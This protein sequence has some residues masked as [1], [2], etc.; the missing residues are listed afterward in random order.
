MSVIAS[1]SITAQADASMQ[2]SADTEMIDENAPRP[3]YGAGGPEFRALSA[4]EINGGDKYRKVRIPPHRYTPLRNNWENIMRPLVEHM[5]IQVRFNPKTRMVEMKT[6]ENTEYQGAL[7]KS[8]D[9]V[10]AFAMGFEVHDAIAL[11]RLD[12]LYVDTFEIKDVKTLQ[13][14]HMSRAIGRIAGQGGKT[15]FAIENAT[16]TRIVLADQKIHILGSFQN[17]KIAR[18]AICKLILGAP[19]GKVYNQMRNVA[20][21]MNE[22]F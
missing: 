9:F 11:L 7:Q 20:S 18:D 22:R 19:P 14:D 1:D 6:S 12:D 13:G 21:R 16:R 10:R 8:A 4:R 15:R 3:V 17:I 5:K 2:G